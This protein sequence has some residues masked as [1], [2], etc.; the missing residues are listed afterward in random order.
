MIG[1]LSAAALLLLAV[2][3]TSAPVRFSL[4]SPAFHDGRPLPTSAEY[5]GFGCTGGNIAPTLRWSG[6]PAGTR[7]FALLLVDP[8]APRP[9]G[10]VHWVLYNI[11]ATATGLDAHTATRYTGGTNNFGQH[12][13]DGPCPPLHD[14]PH[15]YIF[16]LYALNMAHISGPSATSAR[17]L[18][19]MHGHIL[20]SA[21]LTGTFQRP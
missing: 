8:D 2:G 19:A 20:G 1:Q 18:A 3:V 17:L 12:T 10:W 5:H 4:T 16:T 21:R 7:S 14:R 6:V 9:G 11:R 13:Y 15:H